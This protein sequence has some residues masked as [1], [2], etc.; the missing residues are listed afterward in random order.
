ML[1]RST[2]AAA[3]HRRPG[4][5]GQLAHRRRDGHTV[6]VAAQDGVVAGGQRLVDDARIHLRQRRHGDVETAPHLGQDTVDVGAD[7]VDL[8][9]EHDHRHVQPTK[10]AKQQ[11][12]LRLHALDGRDDQDGTIEHA[13]HTLDLGDEVR[14]P[15]RVDEVDGTPSTTN[16]T[17]ADLIVIPRWR[18]SASESVCVVPSS[19]RPMS[20]MTPAA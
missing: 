4:D 7:A 1:R 3:G 11:Q 19:T 16:D 6:D 5:A 12:G 18:S 14:V 10:G 9:D 17:T 15:G 8:V 2:L 13:E 20:S